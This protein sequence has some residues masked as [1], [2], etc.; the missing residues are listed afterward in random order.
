[1]K[2]ALFTIA[3]RVV[4]TCLFVPVCAGLANAVGPPSGKGGICGGFAGFQCAPGLFCDYKP[5]ALCG[6][7]DQTGTC[8]KQPALCSKIFKPVC[9][10][11]DKT[12]ANDCM[13]RAAGTGKSKNR[14][15]K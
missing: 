14:A 6:A 11:D 2:N 15:C 7:A 4:I 12:Y 8:R 3:I 10:C 1:M 9:G 13:R 5:S